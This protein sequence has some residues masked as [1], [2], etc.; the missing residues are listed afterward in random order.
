MT[1]LTYRPD[2]AITLADESSPTGISR[3]A[4]DELKRIG[5]RITALVLPLTHVRSLSTAEELISPAVPEYVTL[6]KQA[7]QLLSQSNVSE[8]A[9][10]AFRPLTDSIRESTLVS[11]DIKEQ[12][13]GVL[14]S[15]EEY[16]DWF[17]RNYAEET[18]E[19]KQVALTPLVQ[20]VNDRLPRVEMAISAISLV[21]DENPDSTP[22]AIP[23]L[24]EL[25]DRCWTEVEDVFLS[26]AQYEDDGETVP[27]SEVKAE[28]G[29]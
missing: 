20:Q 23:I 27:L 19:G 21:L 25:A 12:L 5:Q 29:L 18:N 10:H 16:M 4:R 1:L 17:R 3:N 14:E 15:L 13:Q 2:L 22:S 28:L 8:S 24:S 11:E 26:H 9:R 7:N 6:A